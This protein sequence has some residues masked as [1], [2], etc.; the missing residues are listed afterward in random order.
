MPLV[1]RRSRDNARTPMQWDATRDAGF[2]TGTPWIGVN[3]NHGSINVEQARADPGSVFHYYRQLIRLRHENPIV[4]Y[5]TYDLILDAHEQIYA[6]TRTL[7]DDRL[8]VVLNFTA[9]TPV[10][11][12]PSHIAFAA[13][14][15]LIAN[16][17]V[18]PAEDIRLL[19]L[20]PYEAR[21][22]RLT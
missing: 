5:G 18:D 3:P 19:T 11:A 17:N 16:Y 7:E 21:V 13:T 1:H 2:T 8:L 12:M 20:R 4:A 22:Y 6:Y 14:N 9:D 10:F 15:L